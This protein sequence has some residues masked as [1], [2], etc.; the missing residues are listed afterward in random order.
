MVTRVAAWGTSGNGG[1]F[2][3]ALKPASLNTGSDVAV[4]PVKAGPQKWKSIV[5]TNAMADGLWGFSGDG[6]MFII[7]RYQ[8]AP[9]QFTLQAYNLLASTPNSAVLNV[10][11]T[12]V[13]APTV[14]VSPCGDRLLYVR[15]TQMSPLVGQGTFFRRT[16]FPSQTMVDTYWDGVS[17]TTPSASINGGPVPNPFLVQLNGLKVRPSGTTTFSS[18]Q[19]TP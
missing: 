14:T 17:Q 16:S 1:Y 13:F 6:S 3:L 4:Y 18:L 2:F 11:E 15:W 8:N 5:S 7:T 9:I 12:N 10:S 19:C